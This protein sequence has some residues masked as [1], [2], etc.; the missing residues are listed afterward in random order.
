M[1]EEKKR[2]FWATGKDICL[3]S[4][5]LAM[6]SNLD[7]LLTGEKNNYRQKLYNPKKSLFLQRNYQ[8]TNVKS[9]ICLNHLVD[10]LHF[11]TRE[12][13]VFV[14]LTW[15]TAS[16]HHLNTRCLNCQL[17]ALYVT[18]RS[19]T[20]Q[21]YHRTENWIKW[22]IWKLWDFKMDNFLIHFSHLYKALRRFKHIHS[23]S[24]H[25]HILQL[26][27]FSPF[28]MNRLRLSGTFKVPHRFIFY[29][30]PLFHLSS[31]TG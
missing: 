1:L 30:Y 29:N 26:F 11:K 8:L 25:I 10:F 14:Y 31:W 12:Q 9:T 18:E 24:S 20:P 19:L 5:V 23:C 4:S 2:D 16:S 3:A 7:P 13:S 17:H 28:F 22:V 21:K 27:T 6:N 15:G